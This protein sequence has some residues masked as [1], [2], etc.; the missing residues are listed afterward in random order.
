MFW[1]FVAG[2]FAVVIIP[3]DSLISFFQDMTGKDLSITTYEAQSLQ[4]DSFEMDVEIVT[5]KVPYQDVYTICDSITG[6]A[7]WFCTS[8]CIKYIVNR[9]VKYSYKL[10]SGG[11]ELKA[12]V[13]SV[14]DTTWKV[15]EL[16]T[17]PKSFPRLEKIPLAVLQQAV[18]Y[19][20]S[21]IIDPRYLNAS[22]HILEEYIVIS[23]KE[24]ENYMQ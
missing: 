5:G 9:E 14:V 15:H 12:H 11:G 10:P 2:L 17:C 6:L 7:K 8:P 23:L 24:T 22:Q 1:V 21:L 4:R 20:D 3:K 16:S 13:Y 19:E 18:D